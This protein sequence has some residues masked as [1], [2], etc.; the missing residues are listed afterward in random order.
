[1]YNVTSVRLQ[2]YY[3]YKKVKAEYPDSALGGFTRLLH[4]GEEDEWMNE[5]PTIVVDP[6]SEDIMEKANVSIAWV[7]IDLALNS[8]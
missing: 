1:M 6:L 8:D 3:W 4:T 7:M 2:C 5:I